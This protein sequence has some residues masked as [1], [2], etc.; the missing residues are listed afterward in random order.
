MFVFLVE[1]VA[2]FF[3]RRMLMSYACCREE[4]AKVKGQK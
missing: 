1:T 4:L 3:F 2:L